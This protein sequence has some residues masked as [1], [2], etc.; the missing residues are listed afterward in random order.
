MNRSTWIRRIHRWLAMTFTAT[1]I[2]VTVVV[3]TQEEPSAW[4]Y[5][6]PLLPLAVL[7]VSG[8]YLFVLPH[9]VRRGGGRRP[10]RGGAGG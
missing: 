5:L 1:A 7:L 6:S 4:V 10:A 9:A 8:L 3:L 2:V